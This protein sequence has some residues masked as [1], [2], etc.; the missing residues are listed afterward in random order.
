MLVIS[1]AP[2]EFRAPT[3]SPAEKLTGMMPHIWDQPTK[4]NQ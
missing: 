1:P 4:N 3:N 2:I